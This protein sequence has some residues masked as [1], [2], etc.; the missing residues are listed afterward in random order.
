MEVAGDGDEDDHGGKKV[1]AQE[2]LVEAE[3]DV[4]EVGAEGVQGDEVRV[5]VAGEVEEDREGGHEGDRRSPCE[6]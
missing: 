4:R 6:G 1:V 3:V 2:D 5:Q